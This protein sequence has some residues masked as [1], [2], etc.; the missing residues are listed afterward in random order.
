MSRL[1]WRAPIFVAGL[2]LVSI[3]TSGSVSYLM[4]RDGGISYMVL[5]GAACTILSG[6]LPWIGE[7]AWEEGQRL[8]AVFAFLIF[9]AAISTIAFAAIERSGS[10]MDRANAS[11]AEQ[12]R[13][14][15]LADAAIA[16]AKIAFERATAAAATECASGRGPRCQG[17]EVREREVHN[18]LDA[19]RSGAGNVGPKKTNALL[20]RLVAMLP[21]SEEQVALYEPLVL[22]LT[23]SM[24]SVLCVAIG[25]GRPRDSLEPSDARQI[26]PPT[27]AVSVM[28][29]RQADLRDVAKFML[30]RMPRCDGSEVEIGAVYRTFVD[31]CSSQNLAALD[32]YE[33]ARAFK[34]WCERGSISV[35]RRK[36]GTFVQNVALS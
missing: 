18:A 1:T 29:R 19:A 16:D 5:A 25:L 28:A 21:L 36:S 27:T 13:R 23:L 26:S 22:P 10:A 33:F 7:R 8:A 34:T 11:V 20:S 3:E 12:S 31:W 6:F 2:A 14:I 35:R 24:L 32:P 15:E 17:L 4:N 9:P 30:D